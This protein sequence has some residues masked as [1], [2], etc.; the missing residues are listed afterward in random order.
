M[1]NKCN[2]IS[3]SIAFNHSA[4]QSIRINKVSSESHRIEQDSVKQYKRPVCKNILAGYDSALWVPRQWSEQ[5][6]PAMCANTLVS[7]T[8]SVRCHQTARSWRTTNFLRDN[9]EHLRDSSLDHCARICQITL[10]KRS[11]MPHSNSCTPSCCCLDITVIELVQSQHLF[12]M[13]EEHRLSVQRFIL[14]ELN[15]AISNEGRSAR[16][17]TI[18]CSGNIELPYKHHN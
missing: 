18:I 4:N 8:Q 15:E 14:D 9:D 3:A 13:I 2:K 16:L 11:A 1:I 17:N 7:H 5:R 6:Y 12:T 10:S